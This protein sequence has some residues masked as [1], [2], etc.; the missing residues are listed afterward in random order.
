MKSL[1]CKNGSLHSELLNEGM[2][3][4]GASSFKLPLPG[5][6]SRW[7]AVSP[8]LCLG[9]LSRPP[10]SQTFASKLLRGRIDSAY[11]FWVG[12]GATVGASMIT[13]VMVQYSQYSCSTM[14]LK[15]TS[16]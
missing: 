8:F 7:I 10:P 9:L 2:K 3:D 15:Y 13:N 16:K 14:Y 5:R 4:E 12:A 11:F 1:G 6:T